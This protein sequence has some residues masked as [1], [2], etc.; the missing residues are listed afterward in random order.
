MEK[1]F[2]RFKF[3]SAAGVGFLASAL[4]GYDTILSLLVS[5]IIADLITGL[6][7]AVMK[8][9]VSST[10]LRDGIMRKALIFLV[11]YIAYRVDICIRDINGELPKIGDFTISIRTF[12]IAYSCIEE[13]ISLLENLANIGV[14]VP[15]WVKTILLQV[16]DCTNKSAPKEFLNWLSKKFHININI[17]DNKGEED[18]KSE[19]EEA[20][21]KAKDDIEE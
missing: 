20:K 3:F 12:F 16:S 6:M 11:V 2:E 13:G 4:G 15:K 17:S 9:E 5:L 21:N 14:P 19:S 10:A 8:K 7:H 18:T 1:L